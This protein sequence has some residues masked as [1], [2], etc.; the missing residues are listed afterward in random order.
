MTTNGYRT[1]IAVSVIGPPILVLF[2]IYCITKDIK[3]SLLFAVIFCYFPLIIP[4]QIIYCF[5]CNK[6]RS[7]FTIVQI[8]STEPSSNKEEDNFTIMKKF[9]QLSSNTNSDSN[10]NDDDPPPPYYEQETTV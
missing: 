9:K 5:C 2:I 4:Y 8:P 1:L 10:A 3:I 7:N 6:N